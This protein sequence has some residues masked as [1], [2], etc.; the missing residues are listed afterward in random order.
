MMRACR[1]GVLF[2]AFC[3]PRVLR[4]Y[5]LD[6]GRYGPVKVVEPAGAARDVV[7]LFSDRTG[8]S[9]FTEQTAAALAEAGALVVQINS[10]AYLARLDQL[11]EKCHELVFDA[12]WVSRV[13][14]REEK[15]PNFLTPI[16]AGVGEG[17][18][19]AGLAL[20]EAPA[21]TIAGALELD[22]ESLLSTRR[23]VC[24]SAHA[25]VAHGGFQYGAPGKLRGFW[26]IGLT[27]RASAADR[28]QVSAL[29]RAG[30]PVEVREFGPKLTAGDALRAMIEPHLA[31]QEKAAA[32]IGTLPLSALPVTHPP[33]LMA[34]EVSGDGGWRDLDETIA[35]DLQ[36]DGIPVVGWDSLRYFWSR[37]TPEQTARDLAA[38]IETFM[39]RWHADKV[40]LVGY[41]FGADIMPFAYNRLP[42][43]TRSRVVFIA[44]LG[45]AKA[46]D[47]QIRISDW[48]GVPPGPDALPVV[49]A[50]VKIPAHLIECFYGE[51]EKDTACP[52]L[53]RQGVEVIRAPGGHHFNHDYGPLE[54]DI[55]AGLR[56]RLGPLPVLQA[57]AAREP[58][59]RTESPSKEPLLPRTLAAALLS[60][61][62]LPLLMW[63]IFRHASRL[64]R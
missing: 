63:L 16:V 25:M 22:P 4:A 20:S 11:D 45:L 61:A 8:F 1:I 24:T 38:V 5:G 15:F 3:G 57:S 19:L 29:Q 59:P 54:S 44:L 14:Q 42:A 64:Q 48:L 35:E 2:L 7:I 47:F 53:A 60:L 40:V 36:R 49:P 52:E 43:A 27:A 18:T 9:S 51:S 30:A 56:Q 12:E 13:L 50:A 62:A 58:E 26:T 39:A 32:G 55:L 23:P 46:A 21:A 28:A 31:P 17:G 6:S 34:V 37:K 41:S 33:G 10:P